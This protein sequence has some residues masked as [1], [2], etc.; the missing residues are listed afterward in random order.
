[1][2]STLTEDDWDDLL[3][4]IADGACTPFIGAGAAGSVLPLGRKLA[5]TWSTKY[6]YPLTDDSN[7]TRVAQYLAIEKHAM[8]PKHEVRRLFQR[9]ARPDFHGN[10]PHAVLANLRLPIYI[11]TNYD[12]FMFKALELGGS[13]RKCEPQREVCRWYEPAQRSGRRDRGGVERP[14]PERPLV[15]H[16]HG[17]REV[18]QSLVLTEDDYLEFL[19]TL[20]KRGI[21]LLP[22]P[23][24]EALA[25]SA[26][27]FVGYS[28]ADWTFRVLFRGLMRAVA[29][30]IRYPCIAI[31]LPPEDAKAEKCDEAQNYL[32]RYFEVVT[33]TDVKVHFGDVQEFTSELHERWKRYQDDHRTGG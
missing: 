5:T 29:D 16:L 20:S 19:T 18:P 28:L 30:N 9:A 4:L 25:G 17:Y 6:Q 26:L 7:L 1:M 23:V 15:F 31:Q 24:R 22:P 27:L 12:D 11:T 14:T 3:D 32:R 8:F 33:K 21:E 2:P 13:D 10:E